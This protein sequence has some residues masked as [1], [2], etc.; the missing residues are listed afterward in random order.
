MQYGAQIGFQTEFGYNT[1]IPTGRYPPAEHRQTCFRPIPHTV[2]PN[3]VHFRDSLSTSGYHPLNCLRP[4]SSGHLSSIAAA[5]QNIGYQQGLSNRRPYNLNLFQQMPT[6]NANLFNKND[7]KEEQ[8]GSSP[9]QSKRESTDDQKN[10]SDSSEEMN[11]YISV[12][13]SPSPVSNAEASPKS[14]DRSMPEQSPSPSSTTK[15]S[16]EDTE[17]IKCAGKNFS[18][19]YLNGNDVRSDY[20]SNR[21]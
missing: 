1:T 7:V 10:Q 3:V 14:S 21:K 4:G 15:S 19:V 5:E 8:T 16:S 2:T 12:S 6:S 20:V 9:F 11:E 13:R 17:D 18:F